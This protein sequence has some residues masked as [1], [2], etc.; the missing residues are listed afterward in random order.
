M[1]RLVEATNS[2]VAR[3]TRYQPTSSELSAILDGSRRAAAAI[4]TQGF[5]DHENELAKVVERNRDRLLAA[6]ALEN[7]NIRGNTIEQIIT[8]GVNAH[9][10]DDLEFR[11]PT[12]ERLIVDIKTKLLDRASAPKAY[13][14]DKMLRTLSQIDTSF[15]FF[16][17]G[18]NTDRQIARSR[19]VSIFDPVIVSATRIQT[20]WAGRG[21]RGVT[22]LTGDLS[23]IFEVSY[24]SSV[25]V[26]AGKALLRSFVER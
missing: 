19:L 17:I 12:G 7:V 8:G 22:Q 14:I 1:Q 13:N 21:S 3:L 5:S 25:D 6:A 16:F 20:H 26:E 9:R 4:K 18:L 10:L 15:A 23:R 2:I 11:L 24:R